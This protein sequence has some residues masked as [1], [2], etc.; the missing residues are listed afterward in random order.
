M[1]GVLVNSLFYLHLIEMSAWANSTLV[2]IVVDQDGTPLQKNHQGK[3][4]WGSYADVFY[5]HIS[6]QKCLSEI[7]EQG[8]S[9]RLLNVLLPA[10]RKAAQFASQVES[11]AVPHGWAVFDE[12]WQS[13]I[14]P[15]DDYADIL[16]SD[17]QVQ[18][19][20]R[21]LI[22]DFHIISVKL[23]D[24]YIAAVRKRIQEQTQ[25]GNT[26]LTPKA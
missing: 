17:Q 10:D 2:V 21:G 12:G 25:K 8:T 1:F 7:P 22:Q 18:S 14:G 16:L 6:A 26:N 5:S 3:W 20:V 11:R 9:P 24:K 4:Y 15:T 13:I 19:A 23:P